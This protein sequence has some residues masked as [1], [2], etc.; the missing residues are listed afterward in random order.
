MR[1]LLADS[2]G[3]SRTSEGILP[4]KFRNPFANFSETIESLSLEPVD[5]G[6][7]ENPRFRR[8]FRDCRKWFST[9]RFCFTERGC[10]GLAPVAAQQGDRIA[11]LYGADVPVILR[12][13]APARTGNT[14]ELIGPAYVHGI[15][16]GEVLE[17]LGPEFDVREELIYIGDHSRDPWLVEGVVTRYSAVTGR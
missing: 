4:A 2:N 1:T 12:D 9:R 7:T 15:M 8:L 5:H 13:P 17:K 16:D 11:V 3:D 10:L 14:S 6:P